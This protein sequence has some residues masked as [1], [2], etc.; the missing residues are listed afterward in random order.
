MSEGRFKQHQRHSDEP[1]YVANMKQ[2]HQ[3]IQECIKCDMVPI[4]EEE[5][6]DAKT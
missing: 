5:V 6:K 1:K 4:E 2:F 3:A